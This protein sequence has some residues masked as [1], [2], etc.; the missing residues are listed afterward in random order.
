MR[1]GEAHA[2]KS[3]CSQPLPLN[4][5][6]GQKNIETRRCAWPR[7]MRIAQYRLITHTDGTRLL[8]FL[9]PSLRHLC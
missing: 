6:W 3:Q 9:P 8:C 2:L 5:G 7:V 1:A 4:M